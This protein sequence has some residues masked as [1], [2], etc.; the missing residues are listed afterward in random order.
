MSRAVLDASL[1][2]KLGVVEVG[3]EQALAFVGAHA[4]LAPDFL[5]VEV[6]NV[7]SSKVRRGVI[8]RSRAD[9]LFDTMRALPIATYRSDELLPSARSLAHTLDDT[10]YDCMYVALALRE[11]ALFGT[12]DGKLA[13]RIARAGLLEDRVVRIGDGPALR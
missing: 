5:F 7:L 8:E 9:L 6:A 2:I 1:L 4:L 10:V 13:D 11:G 12:G 3:S